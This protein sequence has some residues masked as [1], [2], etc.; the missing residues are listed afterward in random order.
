MFASF[1]AARHL[2][3]EVARL[4][5]SRVMVIAAEAESGLPDQVVAGL[6][7]AVRHT[8]VVMHV[9]ADVADRARKA[10]R[11]TTRSTSSSA[12]VADR[13]RAWPRRWR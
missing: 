8:E 5:A 2:T 4:G 7:V 1:E 6:P 12:S 9:P 11:A 3:D 10:A 13:P